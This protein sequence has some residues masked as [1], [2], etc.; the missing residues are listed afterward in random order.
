[1]SEAEVLRL[2]AEVLELRN[3]VLAL[4]ARVTALEASEDFEVVREPAPVPSPPQ[5]ARVSSGAST[6]PRVLLCSGRQLARPFR[7][8]CLPKAGTHSGSQLPRKWERF[9]VELA[10]VN[11]EGAQGE[12]ECSWRLVCT[13]FLPLSVASCTPKLDCTPNL[14]Q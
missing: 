12:T 8:T 7:R 11:I 3:L 5:A 9:W 4:S 2:R 1:M 6:P 14:N 13:S 10:G